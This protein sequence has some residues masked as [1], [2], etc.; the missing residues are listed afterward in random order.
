MTGSLFAHNL[1]KE[2]IEIIRMYKYQLHK[3][4][5]FTVLVMIV[6]LCSAQEKLDF[7]VFDF[8]IDQFSTTAQ[9]K[10][11]EKFDGDGYRYAIIKVKAVDGEGGLEGFTFNFGTLNSIVESHDDELWVY[12]QHN[13]KTVTIKRPG[14]KP[15]E[16]YNLETTIQPGKVYEMRITMSRIRKEIERSITKQVL[17]FIVTPSNENAFVK[18]R[19]VKADGDYEPWGAV[20]ETGSIDKIMEFGTYDYIITAP[21]YVQSSGRL[22]LSDSKNTHVEKVTLK[23]NFGFLSITDAY[24]ITGAQVFVDDKMVGT[25]PYRDNTKRWECGSHSLT[26]TNGDL[27]KPFKTTFM[28]VQGD[29]TTL[30]PKLESDFAQATIHVD[31]DAEIFVDGK[32]KGRKT[33]TGPLKA[34]NYIIECKQENH[35][36]TS[37]SINVQADKAEIFEVP[38]PIAITGSV[39]VRSSPS[40]ATIEIDGVEKGTTPKLIQDLMIGGHTIKLKLD[41]HKTEQCDVFIKEGET[42][43]IDVTLSDIAHMT[44][45]SNPSHSKL[46]INGVNVGITPYSKEMSSGDYDIE[47]RHS[48]YQTYQKRIHLDSSHPSIEISL[49]RQYQ[50]PF[51]FYVQPFMQVG[52]NMAVGGSIG[53][54]ISNVN[55]EGYYAMGMKESEMIYWNSVS[56]DKRPCGYTY[57]ANTMGGRLGYGLIF[58]TRLRLTPQIGIGVVSIKSK[59]T[60]NVTPSFDAS[61]A[62]SVTASIGAKLE[63]AFASCLGVYVAPEYDFTIKRSNYFS[64]MEPI[65][66]T[67]KGFASGINL[68]VGL[69]LFF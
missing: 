27:Y 67:V 12:V 36:T 26:I 50:R 58:G 32:S 16:R 14:Y 56:G 33:W 6:Q 31:A 54:Y 35:K 44:I 7:S 22:V 18:V 15:I 52:S 42:E 39:Y 68:R 48:K 60:Y 66:S 8:G 69:S 13:A 28:I 2:D 46:F 30:S 55:I 19:N 51:T 4:V 3:V 5:A 23:P 10:R 64:R 34:G 17:Q 41:N 1:H 11:F 65:S 45:D 38:A 37:M 63:Y 21:D 9:D 62:Y 61:K 53:G 49:N 24:G 43:S 59:K 20:D 47:I 57:K 25:V 40:G 29:T